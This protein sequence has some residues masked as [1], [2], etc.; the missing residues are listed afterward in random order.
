MREG[1]GQGA[2]HARGHGRERQTINAEIFSF[3][4]CLYVVSD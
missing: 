3:A 1:A 4:V 2:G